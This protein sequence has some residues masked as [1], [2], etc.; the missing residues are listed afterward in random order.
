MLIHM[1]S[2]AEESETDMFFIIVI[3]FL[4]PHWYRE[5]LIGI[6]LQYYRIFRMC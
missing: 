5:A 3:S 6:L 2:H 4:L 1:A